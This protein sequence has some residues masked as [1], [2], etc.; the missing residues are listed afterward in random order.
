MLSQ[1]K[2][3]VK[4]NICPTLNYAVFHNHM[5]TTG[6]FLTGLRK[7]LNKNKQFLRTNISKTVRKNE[8]IFGFSGS[9]KLNLE[10]SEACKWKNVVK[11]VNYP[12]F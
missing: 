3:P 11:Y 10:D 4:I 9:T 12:S 8:V 5:L 2:N 7:F 6:R 1:K